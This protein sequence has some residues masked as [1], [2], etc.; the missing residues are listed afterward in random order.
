MTVTTYQWTIE[1][2]HQAIEAG[3]FAH[4][5]VELLE[6]EIVVMSPE[7]EP[8]AYFNTSVADNLRRLLGD[9]VQI[10]D[11]KPIILPNN[12]EPVPDIT[13][14]RPLGL[15]YLEH[16]PYPED[17]FWLIE[18]ANTALTKDLGRKKDIYSNAGIPEYWVVDLKNLQLKVFRDLNNNHYE[19]ELTLTDGLIAPLAFPDVRVEVRQLMR[20]PGT[21]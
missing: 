13:I 3:I 11:A 8:H 1:R 9:L 16:H 2:Y 17:I 12:S 18:F 4:D 10:R 6:G 15:V 21:I 7:R 20:S 14:A 19:T 5:S